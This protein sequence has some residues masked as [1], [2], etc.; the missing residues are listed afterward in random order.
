[1]VDSAHCSL[2]L[3]QKAIDVQ[4]VDCETDVILEHFWTVC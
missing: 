4:I 2:N 1:M 3:R